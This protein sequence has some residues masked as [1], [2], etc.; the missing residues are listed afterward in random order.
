MKHTSNI[1]MALLMA[2]VILPFGLAL[3]ASPDGGFFLNET[4]V[5]F[6]AN[7][8][9]SILYTLDGTNPLLNGTV[10]NGS[11]LVSARS[12]TSSALAS[13]PETMLAISALPASTL[14]GTVLRAVEVL[15]NGSVLGKEFTR[16]YFIGFENSSFTTPV[17]SIVTEQKYLDDYNIGMMIKGAT[18]YNDLAANGGNPTDPFR[19]ANWNNDSNRWP[20]SMELYDGG[21]RKL[22]D[23]I[24][25]RVSGATSVQYAQKSLKLVYKSSTGGPSKTTYPFWGNQSVAEYER[26]RL[27]QGSQDW[28]SGT[29]IRD[30]IVTEIANGMN[31]VAP[32]CRQAVLFINGEYW[33]PYNMIEDIHNKQ[34]AMMYNI[35]KS[36]VVLLEQDGLVQEGNAADGAAWQTF[37]A[38]LQTKNLSNSADWAWYESKVNVESVIDHYNIQM[39]MHNNGYPEDLRIFRNKGVPKPGTPA[40]GRYYFEPKD[41]DQT[42]GLY[43]QINY[44]DN[45]LQLFLSKPSD[46]YAYA[47]FVKAWENPEFRV[48]FV[49][50]TNELLETHFSSVYMNATV[51]A[52]AA[53][54]RPENPRGIDRWNRPFGTG[55]W[56]NKVVG[57]K[58]WLANRNVAYRGFVAELNITVPVNNSTNTTNTTNTTDPYAIIAQLQAD[59]VVLQNQLLTSQTNLVVCQN[60]LSVCLVQKAVLQVNLSACMAQLNV[61]IPPV[62]QTNTTN[63]TLP[64]VNNTNSTNTTLPPVNSTGLVNVTIAQWY[65]K[66]KATTT[67][68]VFVCN[69]NVNATKYDWYTFKNGV[70]VSKNLN[71]PTNTVYKQI[72]TG[73]GTYV[74][75]CVA[76]GT[77]PLGN[78]SIAVTV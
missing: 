29:Q 43:S 51:D 12:S 48:R 26:V 16:T 57:I 22:T 64:P 28:S 40:D 68:F 10:A 31:V 41:Q 63:T 19:P 78:G 54:R 8:G 2:I 69:Q 44:S 67:D 61:T 18:Y 66:V 42:M 56:E 58:S 62:N 36:D 45:T 13:N 6:T 37:K 9:N 49:N 50:R 65:P 53:E 25:L 47:L 20:A 17:I 52:V 3:N 32:E 75:T 35:S 27:R 72:A 5:T 24:E 34:L 60:S 77:S 33:G 70:E 39:F 38:E 4:I 71:Q 11:V 23:V 59:I 76:K 7:P 15:P 30:C 73:T 1:L 14:K 74:Q 55:D 21:Q 46:D